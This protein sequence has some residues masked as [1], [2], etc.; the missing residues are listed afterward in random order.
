[1]I[2]TTAIDY[3]FVDKYEAAKVA[4]VSTHT[5]KKYS[6]GDS[7]DL[8]EGIHYVRFNSRVTRYRVGLVKH[9][10]ENRHNIRKHLAVIDQFLAWDE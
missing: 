9:W 10:A 6:A 7:P 4:G 3:S 2:Q 5:L 1:M 8:I